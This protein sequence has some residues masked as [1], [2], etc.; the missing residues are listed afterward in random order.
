MSYPT[1]ISYDEA[2]QILRSLPLRPLGT[3]QIHFKDA[4]NRICAK[5]VRAAHNVPSVPTSAMDGYAI[6]WRDLSL[7]ESSGL[8]LL[9]P[10]KA[11]NPTR[12]SLESG[13]AIKTFTGSLLPHNADTLIIIEHIEQRGDSIV[14]N[15]LGRELVAGFKQGQWVRQVGDNY[16][17]GELLLSP[18][19]K[20]GA[21]EIGLL[22]EL[23]CSFVEVYQRTRVGVLCVGDEIVEVGQ[24]LNEEVSGVVRS[25]NTHL[26]ESLL[27]AMG[28]EPLI[29]PIMRDD[30]V[31][32]RLAYER[33]L[34]ECDVLLSTGGMSV[35]DYDFTKEIMQELTE[36]HFHKV[37]LK[38]GK[39]V[40]CGIYKQDGRQ[41]IALGLPG[42]PNSCALTFLLFGAPLLA[43]LQGR[44]W[45][46]FRL[47][48]QLAEPL[49][50]SDTRMEFRA[51]DVRSEN[52][53]LR[54]SFE[55]KKSLQ[56]SMINNL[57][58]NTALALLPENGGDLDAGERVEIIL[59]SQLVGA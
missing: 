5:E 46:Q 1:M 52:G 14:L 39:P 4:L 58:H 49:K 47:S 15:E 22:A 21:F 30:R 27:R 12:P 19:D 36:M 51:C 26:L 3:Q 28:Q 38:P 40:A 42:Y 31:A 10:N 16:K 32:L 2:L 43:R 34:G 33:A 29:Y 44:E 18:G 53:T 48:A 7:L 57:T 20:I 6:A 55:S 35:G 54:V 9:A 59:L 8:R 17:Q 23:N 50:R 41:C 45:A 25:V 24:E 13:C 56:S 37:R 11:G